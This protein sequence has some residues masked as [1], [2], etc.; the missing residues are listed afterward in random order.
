MQPGHEVQI[1]FVEADESAWPRA[2][3][4]FQAQLA[5]VGARGALQ[6]RPRLPDRAAGFDLISLDGRRLCDTLLEKPD[7]VGDLRR[8]AIINLHTEPPGRLYGQLRHLL[9]RHD[10]HLKA[11]G[12]W[13]FPLSWMAPWFQEPLEFPEL[14]FGS[15]A[16]PRVTRAPDRTWAR[17]S[18]PAL[19]RA[20]EPGPWPAPRPCY[21]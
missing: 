5:M 17:R 16:S 4:F 15:A 11:D 9:G 6:V 12:L 7:L 8:T 2:Q 10:E 20:L 3:V 19:D 14:G 18:A 21:P 1:L 13:V